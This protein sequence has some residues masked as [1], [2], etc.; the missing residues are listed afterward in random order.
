MRTAVSLRTSNLTCHFGNELLQQRAQGEGTS[1][2]LPSAPQERVKAAQGYAGF[3]GLQVRPPTTHFAL[4]G[5]WRVGQSFVNGGLAPF[6]EE[7]SSSSHAAMALAIAEVLPGSNK[8]CDC[9][10]RALHVMQ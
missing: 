2:A 3:Q 5:R 6:E 1:V 4:S 7:N 10:E 9:L 8:G